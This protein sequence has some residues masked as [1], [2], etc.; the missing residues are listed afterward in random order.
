MGSR[1]AN[2]AIPG[3]LLKQPG[4][5]RDKKYLAAI[6]K[7]PCLVCRLTP[8][9]EAAHVRMLSGAGMGRKPGDRRTLPACHTCHMY[10]HSIGEVP[11]WAEMQIDPIAVIVELVEAYPNQELMAAVILRHA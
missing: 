6:R 4:P 8:C 9:G 2:T 3:S 7:L 1:I 11:F 10:Q 5:L